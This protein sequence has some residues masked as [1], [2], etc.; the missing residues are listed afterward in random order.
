[1]DLGAVPTLPAVSL[2]IGD[3]RDGLVVRMPNWL[4][5]SV[6]ALP[7]LLQMRRRLP[8]CC[9]LF[10]VCAPGLADLFAAL[11]IVDQVIPLAAAHRTWR[12]ADRIRLSRTRAGVGLLCSNSLR[13]AIAFRFAGIPRLFGAAARGRS[14]LLT[15]AF[16]FPPRRDRELHGL[17]HAG[18]YLAMAQA[19]GA[20]PW[21]GDFPAFAPRTEPETTP[22]E[23][24]AAMDLPRFLA[25]APGAAYGDAKRW[26]EENFLAVCRDW[27]ADGG[28]VVLL[29]AGAEAAVAARIAEQLP[30]QHVANLAGRTTLATLLPVLG[31]ATACLANDSGLMHLAAALGIPGVAIFGSTDPSA[32]GPLSSRWTILHRRESCSPCFCR[33]CP[34]GDAIC[35]RKI[36][37]QDASAALRRQVP[38]PE[39]STAKAIPS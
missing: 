10:V 4:G 33:T 5:D 32:T 15:R 17:H 22:P 25:V 6:M 23:V 38:V 2:A 27:L 24:L 28:S 12:R 36:T 8:E 39:Q 34:R 1:V 3:W 31:R 29:G 16:R 14:L 19:L 18:R 21:P 9:G 35:L 26:P 37:P 30:P 13:D 20:A 7:A 11:P